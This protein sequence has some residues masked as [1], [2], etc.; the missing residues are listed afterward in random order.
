MAGLGEVVQSGAGASVVGGHPIQVRRIGLRVEQGQKRV[1]R[2]PHRA[3][4]RHLDR[5]PATDPLAPHVHL[6]HRDTLGIEL[7]LRACEEI[8]RARTTAVSKS[9]A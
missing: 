8:T 6:D 5:Y 4:E 9:G 2:V 1:N 7:P 3:Q